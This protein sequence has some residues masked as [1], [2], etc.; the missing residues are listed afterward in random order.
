MSKKN[1]N[2][3]DLVGVGLAAWDLLFRL[4]EPPRFDA[5]LHIT[6]FNQ[7][8]GGPTS[9][10][11]AAASKLGAKTCLITR[12]GDDHYG[13]MIKEN[14]EEYG[15]MTILQREEGSS[16]CVVVVFVNRE[17]GERTFLMGQKYS[18]PDI[19]CIPLEPIKN[20]EYLLVDSH[21][22]KAGI[23]SAETARESKTKVIADVEA[24]GDDSRRLIELSDVLILPEKV[25][26]VYVGDD[27]GKAALVLLDKGP[28][29]VVVTRGVKGC[30]LAHDGRT[31][32]KESYP[33]DVVDTTGAGDVFHGA[34]IAGLLK[35][36]DYETATEFASGASAMN[37][38]SLGGRSGIP[39]YEELVDFLLERSPGWDERKAGE[40]NK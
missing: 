24:P 8:G 13:D 37:C 25:A 18:E 21:L 28:E 34:F 33:V 4:S 2:H 10:G 1:R 7:Q 22:S 11:L 9:T 38:K 30:V 35:G 32:E 40:Q 15:V 23:H 3:F 19:E 17:T 12:V 14:L 29:V 26:S 27:L 6:E 5:D 36:Y 16:S 31:I 39:T 20:S